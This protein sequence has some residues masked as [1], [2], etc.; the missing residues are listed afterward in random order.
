ML[1][2]EHLWLQRLLE[3]QRVVFLTLC[4]LIPLTVQDWGVSADNQRLSMPE[5]KSIELLEA[6]SLL[7]T[8]ELVDSALNHLVD[9]RS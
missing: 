2:V 4:L 6:D 8:L 9:L 5:E 7:C 3:H 1:R